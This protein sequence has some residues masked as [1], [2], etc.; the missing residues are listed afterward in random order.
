MPTGP[1][2]ECVFVRRL[3][4][5][6]SHSRLAVETREH[7]PGMYPKEQLGNLGQLEDTAYHS[8]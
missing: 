1:G 3:L 5:V 7:M 6:K 2:A 8:I 4:D